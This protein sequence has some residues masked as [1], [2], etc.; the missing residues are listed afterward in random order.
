MQF[1]NC[2]AFILIS[3]CFWGPI[4]IVIDNFGNFESTKMDIFLILIF[5]NLAE[6]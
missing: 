3:V 5:W 2:A 6:K 4:S 1:A